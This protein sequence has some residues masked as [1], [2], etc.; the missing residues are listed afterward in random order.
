MTS[1]LKKVATRFGKRRRAANGV[2]SL[3]PLGSPPGVRYRLAAAGDLP[4]VATLLSEIM[5]VHGVDAP[6]AERLA[7]VVSSLLDNPSHRFVLAETDESVVGLCAVLISMSTWS[8]GKACELQDV[9][10][11][12]RA[13]RSGV[14]RGLV[15][16]AAEV[17]R[18]EG[19]GRLQLVTEAWNL[20]AH[21]FY[22]S[23]GFQEKTCLYFERPLEPPSRGRDR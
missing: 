9:I 14:G 7:D 22:R 3:S 13:R 4:A 21:D 17:G 15:E 11:T 16:A 6:R 18:R 23:L 5:A 10:V 8:A 19:C 20:P 2:G 1:S 12:E